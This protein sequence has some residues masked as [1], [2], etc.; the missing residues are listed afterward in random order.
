MTFKIHRMCCNK[1]QNGLEVIYTSEANEITFYRIYRNHYEPA[2]A[3]I[4]ENYFYDRENYNIQWS[5]PILWFIMVD[6][7]VRK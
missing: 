6:H 3:A 7:D 4:N 1:T 5:R 2:F